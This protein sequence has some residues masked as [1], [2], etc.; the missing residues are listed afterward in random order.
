MHIYKKDTEKSKPFSTFMLIMIKSLTTEVQTRSVAKVS[1]W[2]KLRES[3]D[4]TKRKWQ[5]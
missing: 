3:K 1:L 2:D 5:D 4:K